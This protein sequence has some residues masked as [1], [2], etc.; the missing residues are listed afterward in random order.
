MWNELA[1][2]AVLCTDNTIVLI[3][4]PLCLTPPTLV[5]AFCFLCVPAYPLPVCSTVVTVTAFCCT[6]LL[7]IQTSKALNT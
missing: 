1:K 7:R 4:F 2:S 6:S 3:F 5:S